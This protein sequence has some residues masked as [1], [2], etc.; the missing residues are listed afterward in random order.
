[1][2][3]LVVSTAQ[4]KNGQVTV[5]DE[6]KRELDLHD[7]DQLEAHVVAGGM[8]IRRVARTQEDAERAWEGL[9]DIIRRP[10]GELPSDLEGFE[11]KIADEIKEM[12]KRP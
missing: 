12:R 2:K 8:F 10:K 11:Q 9:F 4:L 3:E 5:P 1:M 6:I 7:G